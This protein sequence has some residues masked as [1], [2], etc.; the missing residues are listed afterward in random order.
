MRKPD[1]KIAVMVGSDSGIGR[2]FS[3]QFAREGVGVTIRFHNDE[4]GVREVM[5][6][7][8]RHGRHDAWARADPCRPLRSIARRASSGSAKQPVR[9]EGSSASL[10]CTK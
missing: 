9:A 7:I 3:E 5:G 10:H 8:E 1:G 2:A 6:M 4:H